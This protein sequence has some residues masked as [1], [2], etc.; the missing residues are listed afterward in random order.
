MN[1]NNYIMTPKLFYTGFLRND[2][3]LREKQG[4]PIQEAGG[5]CKVLSQNGLCNKKYL[6]PIQESNLY[7][8]PECPCK[9]P[10]MRM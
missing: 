10:N 7:Y 4:L 5:Q 9:N 1:T 2:S 3:K 6:Y 8:G